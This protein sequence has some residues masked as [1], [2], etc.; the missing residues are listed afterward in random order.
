MTPHNARPQHSRDPNGNDWEANQAVRYTIPPAL[1]ILISRE[2][3]LVRRHSTTPPP[4]RG[5][6]CHHQWSSRTQASYLCHFMLTTV[7]NI[8]RVIFCLSHRFNL[9]L[10]SC[11]S[12]VVINLRLSW[13]SL[14]IY[15][16]RHTFRQQPPAGL[17]TKTADAAN[18]LPRPLASVD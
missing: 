2:D 11:G 4:H 15:I 12:I 3:T 16:R 18:E 1:F 17:P 7:R 13:F 5:P 10:K 8:L 9:I 6:R 14:Y